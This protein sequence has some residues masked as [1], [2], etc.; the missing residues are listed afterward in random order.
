MNRSETQIREEMNPKEMKIMN[1]YSD[2]QKR[3]PDDISFFVDTLPHYSTLPSIKDMTNK[4]I[5]IQANGKPF[6][7]SKL[8]FT[9]KSHLRHG[10]DKSPS[11]A[12]MKEIMGEAMK[13][14]FT[15]QPVKKKKVVQIPK[16][17][18]SQNTSKVKHA[19]FDMY[20]KRK[21]KVVAKQEVENS[22]DEH[23]DK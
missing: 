23:F 19:K 9:G 20:Q 11:E 18:S 15:V 5:K 7:H 12:R 16:E 8:N 2:I 1:P 13:Q 3:F 6:S 14:K 17:R 10:N 22:D 4:T 21:S